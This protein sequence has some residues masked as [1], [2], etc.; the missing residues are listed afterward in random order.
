M[1]TLIGCVNGVWRQVP[2]F[3]VFPRARMIDLLLEG[4]SPREAGTV[5]ETGWSNTEIF[6]DYMKNHLLSSY[7]PLM[8]TPLC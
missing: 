8:M 5:S 6:S 4:A 3:F 2:H 7:L 1:T